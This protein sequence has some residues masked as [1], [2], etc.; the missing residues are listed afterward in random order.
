LGQTFFI[1]NTVVLEK[2]GTRRACLFFSLCVCIF[3]SRTNFFSQRNWTQ[4]HRLWL[5]ICIL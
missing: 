5:F 4:C 3:H 2:G 1:Y